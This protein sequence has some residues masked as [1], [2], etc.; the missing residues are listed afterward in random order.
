MVE[1]LA[2]AGFTVIPSQGSVGVG[3]PY[4]TSTRPK[5]SLS[6]LFQAEVA[7]VVALVSDTT[8]LK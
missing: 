3:K 5:Q 4:L 1:R 2:S 8:R 7:R 6:R